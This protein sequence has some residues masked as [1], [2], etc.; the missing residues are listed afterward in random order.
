[1][2]DDDVKCVGRLLEKDTRSWDYLMRN[3]VP[4]LENFGVQVGL[5]REESRDSVQEVLTSLWE[6][7][8]RV[9]REYIGKASF[10]TY[11]AKIAHRDFIDF[12]RKK[13]REDRK[14]ELKRSAYY[15]DKHPNGRSTVEDKIDIDMLLEKLE[16]K[17]KLL[18][19]LIYRDG[20]S[21]REVAVIFKTKASVVDVWHFRL[22]EKLKKLA[23]PE[24]TGDTG[25]GEGK[26]V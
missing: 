12:L 25:G 10:K 23:A 3:Y 4:F 2:F 11:I 16:P 19:K 26:E 22:R 20:L 1:V 13:N 24:V 21:S 15:I 17:D 14:V 5:G 7:D 9:L 18:A 8:G 6:H